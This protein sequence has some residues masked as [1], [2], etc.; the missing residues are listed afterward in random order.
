MTTTDSA[1]GQQSWYRQALP[2]ESRAQLDQALGAL[3]HANP[4]V[5]AADMLGNLLR[6][7]A[8]NAFGGAGGLPPSDPV[9]TDIAKIALDRAFDVALLGMGLPDGGAASLP[10]VAASGLAGGAAGMLGFLPDAIFTT[11]VIMR[12]I[13]RA[14]RAAGEDLATDSARAACVQVFFLRAGDESGYLAARLMLGGGAARGLIARAAS[15][16]GAML[17]EKFAAGA[18]PV[19]SAASAAVLNAAFLDHY[20][21]LARAHFTI[22]RLERM[23]G[24]EAIRLAAGWP[25]IAADEPFI[26]D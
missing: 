3:R 24:K 7:A 16:W 25:V 19:L 18:V 4:V 6:R 21:S 22:R 1:T 23:H 14:A 12:E 15:G 2:A 9:F 8:G 11:L 20:R 10:A 5:R 26:E 17:G 13:A